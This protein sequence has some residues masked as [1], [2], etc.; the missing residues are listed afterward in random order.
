MLFMQR[1][2]R[3]FLI[4]SVPL[5][6]HCVFLSTFLR[7]YTGSAARLTFSGFRVYFLNFFPFKSR[8]SKQIRILFV[9]IS[10]HGDPFLFMGLLLDLF[11]SGTMYPGYFLNAFL[12][13]LL[14]LLIIQFSNVLLAA[15]QGLE[16]LRPGPIDG[17][18]KLI[19]NRLRPSVGS[20]EPWHRLLTRL[21]T[22]LPF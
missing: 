2:I 8:L 10:F 3:T 19:Q 16:V 4:L 14:F 21:R 7:Y 13:R 5:F 6:I 15:N 20:D 9:S 11:P 18:F 1:R 12:L 22:E 17:L